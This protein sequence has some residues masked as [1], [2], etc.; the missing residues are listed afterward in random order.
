VSGTAVIAITKGGANM[1][2]GLRDGLKG[3]SLYL[4]EKVSGAVRGAKVIKGELAPEVG[5]LF[6]KC[7]ALVFVMAAG[8]VVRLIAPHIKDKRTDPA[9]VVLD[10]DGRSVV[11]LLSGHLGGANALA[12]RIAK[13]T[14]GSAVITTAS[15]VRGVVSVDTLARSLGSVVEDWDKAKKVTAALVN[16]ETVSVYCSLGEE[17]LA[18]AVKGSDKNLIVLS[19]L[20]DVYISDASASIVISPRLID[21][22]ELKRPVAVLRPKTLVVGIGCNRG[23]SS[24]QIAW[25]Y[26]RTLSR[27]GLSLLSVR[28]IATITG[29][30]DEEGLLEFAGSRGLK[31][32]FISKS[33]L[34]KAGT[35]SGPSE[36]VYRNMGVYGVCEPAALASAGSKRLIVEKKKTKDVTLAVAEVGR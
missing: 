11:S 27:H 6:R 21:T 12:E 10:E 7:D 25:L 33:R 32:D 23:T 14:G 30:R 3:A 24:R 28:N 20:E 15:D 16:G 2:A 31:I 9:V 13:L 36:A 5:R 26:D 18:K 17:R 1:A 22:A 8:I 34:T 35:P 4:P 19:N 29:K